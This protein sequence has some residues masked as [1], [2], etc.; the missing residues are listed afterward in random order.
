MA[1]KRRGLGRGLGALIP[2]STKPTS[3]QK[4][5]SSTQKGGS[6]SPSAATG[7]KR[8]A[9]MGRQES[10]TVQKKTTEQ[11][12]SPSLAKLPAPK[13]SSSVRGGLGRKH[14]LDQE[15]LPVP[16]DQKMEEAPHNT[17]EKEKGTKAQPAIKDKTSVAAA[18]LADKKVAADTTAVGEK[19]QL[20]RIKPPPHHIRRGKNRRQSM[21][22][23]MNCPQN[24]NGRYPPKLF[25]RNQPQL[26]KRLNRRPIQRMF[27]VKH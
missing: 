8:A 10:G 14:I 26:R 3:E 18:D 23:L 1:E 11:Q 16:T 4:E 19:A 24:Q 27:H 22:F 21:I 6:T 7:K 13:K 5:V 2:N 20:L 9:G 17:Q 12:S 15:V 25:L